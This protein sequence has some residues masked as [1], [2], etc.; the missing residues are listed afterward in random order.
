VTAYGRSKL[1]AERVVRESGL[2][3]SIVRPPM[4]YGPRDVEVFKAFQAAARGIAPVFGRGTQELSAIHVADLVQ[5]LVLVA[6]S[7][8]A[9]R[10]TYCACHPELF[11]SLDFARGI[12][13]AVGRKARIVHLPATLARSLL[14]VTGMLARIA[15]RATVLNRDKA[16]EFLAPAWT[17]DPAPLARDTG[18]EA[19][20]DLAAGLADTARWYREQGWIQP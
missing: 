15:G 18:W 9:L 19:R 13:R 6:A 4:V 12:A 17:G 10:Q 1:A 20:Y 2:P 7:G 3:W 16:N 14:T 11:T 8:A 5:A